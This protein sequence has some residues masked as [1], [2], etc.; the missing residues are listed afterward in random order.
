MVSTVQA[1]NERLR[2]RRC[3]QVDVRKRH[4]LIFSTMIDVEG[5][6]G[7]LGTD[8]F[9]RGE[10]FDFPTACTNKWRRNQQD[11]GQLCLG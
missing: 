8:V 2:Q 4:G 11:A 7:K 10:V 9:G 3:V 5:N 1:A 6:L